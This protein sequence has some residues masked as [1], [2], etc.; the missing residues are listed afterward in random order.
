MEPPPDFFALGG[1]DWI[2]GDRVAVHAGK[3][4]A[5]L[6]RLAAGPLVFLP[7][8]DT[9]MM[10]QRAGYRVAL[11]TGAPEGTVELMAGRV[12]S[13]PFMRAAAGVTPAGKTAWLAGAGGGVYVDDQCY[14]TVPRGWSFVHYT[15]Q[16][17]TE[18]YSQLT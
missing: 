11:L 16:D 5:Y 15:G 9:A 17:A 2:R 12:P 10:L 4:A 18:L 6:R 8:W 3:N 1:H 7:A 14:V 13:W